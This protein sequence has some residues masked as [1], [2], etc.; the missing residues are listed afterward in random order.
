[1]TMTLSTTPFVLTE[2]MMS[3]YGEAI[4]ERREVMGFPKQ[5]D[6]AEASKRLALEDQV[7]FAKFSQ[8]WLSRLELDRDGETI[9]GANT[10]RLRTLAY[11]LGW[12]QYDFEHRVG[13]AIGRVPR[14]D[15]DLKGTMFDESPKVGRKINEGVFVRHGGKV[16]AGLRN[17]GNATDDVVWVEI[18]RSLARNYKRED[19]F[20]LDV[21]GDSM[22]SEDVKKRI[23]PGSSVVFHKNLQPKPGQAIVCWLE[24]YDIGVLKVAARNGEN[25]TVLYSHN[26]EH[27]PIIVN[28]DNPA[29]W[30]GTVVG[31]WSPDPFANGAWAGE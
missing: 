7:T 9:Q 3:R 5:G 27:E 23:S 12:G 8:Q 18:P 11:L 29:I 2:A 15:D 26:N 20:V 10:K 4:L 1:M 30:Q 13:V 25:H 28:K 16:N 22:M 21:E 19:L 6:L 31:W 14:L 17:I 24:R